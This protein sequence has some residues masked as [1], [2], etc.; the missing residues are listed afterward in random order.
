M[1]NEDLNSNLFANKSIRSKK[2]NNINMNMNIHNTSMNKPDDKLSNFS[3]NS[4]CV[5]GKLNNNPIFGG[6]EN[7][8]FNNYMNKD[9][10]KLYGSGG[11]NS[12]FKNGNPN[13]INNIL[14]MNNPNTSFFSTENNPTKLMR[15][16]GASDMEFKFIPGKSVQMDYVE[17]IKLLIKQ[18]DFLIQL[19]I[20]NILLTRDDGL[21]FRCY[22]MLYSFFLMRSKILNLFKL[23]EYKISF[24]FTRVYIYI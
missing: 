3:L 5:N 20:Q 22:S 17:Q 4:Y 13:D 1:L 6:S 16:P 9:M 14:D 10:H 7:N 21:N 2:Y 8:S 24:N 15:D 11:D 18:Y 23:P 19:I 12:F